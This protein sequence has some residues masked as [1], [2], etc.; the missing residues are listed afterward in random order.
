MKGKDWKKLT[1]RAIAVLGLCLLSGAILTFLVAGPRSGVAHSLAGTWPATVEFKG[2]TTQ[3]LLPYPVR[4]KKVG[5]SPHARVTWSIPVTLDGTLETSGVLLERPLFSS[6]IVWD[7]VT[8]A[9]EGNFGAEGAWGSGF[10]ALLARLP[11]DSTGAGSHLLQVRGQG[12]MD[13]GG[14]LGTIWLGSHLDLNHLYHKLN[15]RWLFMTVLLL[16]GSIMGMFIVVVRPGIR[17]FFWTSAFTGSLGVYPFMVSSAG[18]ELFH[19]VTWRMRLL[20][21]ASAFSL[22][23]TLKMCA[24]LARSPEEKVSTWAAPVLLGLGGVLLVWPDPIALGPGKRLLD[25]LSLF[26]A[27]WCTHLLLAGVK[28]GVKE[29]TPLLVGGLCL[30]FGAGWEVAWQHAYAVSNPW[31]APGF[32]VF[33]CCASVTLVTRF[34]DVS[35]RYDQLL[36]RARDAVLAVETNGRIRECNPAAEALFGRDLAGGMLQDQAYS[37]KVEDLSAHLDCAPMYRR[38]EFQVQAAHGEVWVE[39]MAEP[40]PDGRV[41]LVMRDITERRAD[42]SRFVQSARL[43]VVGRLAGVVAHDL[44]NTLT[45]L[46]GHLSLLRGRGMDEPREK[47][48]D[49]METIVLGAAHLSRRLLT[50]SRGGSETASPVYLG[51]GVASAVELASTMMPRQ[52][53]IVLE[54]AEGLPPV[55][56]RRVELEQLLVNLLLNARDAM[57]VDGGIIRVSVQR[58]HDEPDWLRLAIEDTGPG[59]PAELMER[60]WEPFFTTKPAGRGT[61]L[62]LSAVSQVARS[63]GARLRTAEPL[64]GSGARF[65]VDLPIHVG[66][67]LGAGEEG[68]GGLPVVVVEDDPVILELVLHLLREEGMH[69]RGYGTAEAALQDPE[70]GRAVLLVTDVALPGRSGLDLARD[71]SRRN[72]HLS[73]VVVSGWIPE[74]SPSLEHG[75]V[76][77]T[78]PFAPELLVKAVREVLRVDAQRDSIS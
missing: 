30:A 32:C 56:G 16:T 69:A 78:K 39:S 6:E 26:V 68:L 58:I 31:L 34:S 4:F 2:S 61:G 19:D 63:H 65:E 45:A 37:E 38:M 9:Q 74:D 27:A 20:V 11:P 46:M 10:Q 8:V 12:A 24:H 54:N 5:I 50:V 15:N 52:I 72:P 48:V 1:R 13:M 18:W 44:N 59:I 77:L 71:M 14:T 41:L 43:E 73:V 60:I 62:G 75:W 25:L 57:G 28:A 53:R 70:A 3:R 55:Q 17:E 36:A 22:A 51:E 66:T 35:S 42:E 7:G 33:T 47:R 21:A 76:C 40:L 67:A 49:Q 64:S 23:A 29:I